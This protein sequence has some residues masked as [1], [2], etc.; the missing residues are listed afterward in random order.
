LFAAEN[1]IFSKSLSWKYEFS[2]TSPFPS[3]FWGADRFLSMRLRKDFE[4]FYEKGGK[5][6]TLDFQNLGWDGRSGVDLDFSRADRGFAPVVAIHL[7]MYP[8]IFV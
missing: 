3:I 6:C 4:S 7:R 8:S 5:L 2:L 1:K